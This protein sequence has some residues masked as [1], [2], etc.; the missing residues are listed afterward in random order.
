M[1][2]KFSRRKF[3]KLAGASTAAAGLGAFLFRDEV[4][5]LASNFFKNRIDFLT[6]EKDLAVG[7]SS[8]SLEV[9]LKDRIHPGDLPVYNGQG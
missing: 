2:K 9:P 1:S 6:S 3:L 5:D 4:S 7:K 8:F